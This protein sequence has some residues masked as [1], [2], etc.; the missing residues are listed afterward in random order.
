MYSKQTAS[1]KV[2]GEK[3]ESTPLKSQ[4]RKGGP[5]FLY[6]FIRALK[7]IARVI[8]QQNLQRPK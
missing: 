3:L 5:L 4:T 1:I 6:S 7:V 2:N 8:I